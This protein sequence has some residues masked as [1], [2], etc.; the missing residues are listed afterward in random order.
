MYVLDLFKEPLL[1]V[2]QL[3]ESRGHHIDGA[4]L[5]RRGR[6]VVGKNTNG[7]GV[8]MELSVSSFESSS[9][10]PNSSN[11]SIS[12]VCTRVQ[13]HVCTHVTSIHINYQLLQY[14]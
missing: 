7:V 6:N 12:S 4:D 13:V 11:S 9:S 5:G 14:S 3:S 1:V 2:H 10:D 8:T